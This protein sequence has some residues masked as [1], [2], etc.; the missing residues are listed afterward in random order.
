[1]QLDMATNHAFAEAVIGGYAPP[2][3]GPK[4]VAIAFEIDKRRMFVDAHPKARKITIS[5]LN[6]GLSQAATI[7]LSLVFPNASGYPPGDFKVGDLFGAAT[8]TL[9]TR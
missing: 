1:M 7:F 3:G 6:L 9:T 2:L 5:G 8:L 4:G